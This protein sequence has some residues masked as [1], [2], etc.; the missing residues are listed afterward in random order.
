MSD[1]FNS[2][3]TATG[4][5]YKAINGALLLITVNGV[6]ESIKTSYGDTTAVRADVVVLDGSSK[7]EVFGDTLLFPKVL[8]SQTR[9]Q[10]GKKV[11]GRLGQG[12]AKPGQSAPWTLSEATDADKETA[13]KYLA[14]VA[15]HEVTTPA[16]P[17]EQ[18][19]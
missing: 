1:E 11:L 6:E 14:Y 2:P 15:T 16:A 18:P 3:S 12:N 9:S 10:V 19:W 7:G 17:V 4:I 13:R 5:D 8:V